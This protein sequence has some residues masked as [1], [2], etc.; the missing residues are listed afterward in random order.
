MIIAIEVRTDGEPSASDKTDLRTILAEAIRR[1]LTGATVT[2][3]GLRVESAS[4]SVLGEGFKIDP[5]IARSTVV[6]DH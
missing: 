4:V 2:R 3:S 5:T 6:F 1:Y